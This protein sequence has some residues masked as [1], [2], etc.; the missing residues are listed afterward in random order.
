[1]GLLAK[2]ASSQ[3]SVCSTAARAFTSGAAPSK[4]E[5]LHALGN[6]DD[7]DADSAVV[8]YLSALYKGAKVEPSSGDDSLEFTSKIE[9]KYMAAETVEF[10][11]QTI[12]LPLS[13]NEEGAA[14]VKRYVA[15]LLALGK[16]AGF[17]DPMIETEK[18]LAEAAHVSDSV[19]ELLTRARTVM[20]PELH[21]SLTEAVNAVEAETGGAAVPLDGASPAYKKFADKAKAI[22][23][24]N[25]L[26]WKLLVDVKKSAA[27]EGTKDKLGKE[28]S[29]WLQSARVA[30]AVAE[31]AALRSEASSLLDKQLGKSAEQVRKE[32]SAALAQAMRRAESAKG[33][34]W[35]QAFLED[36]E[37]TKWFD[38]CVAENPAVG[39]KVAK[40]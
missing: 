2:T 14:S 12:A 16:K 9:K 7:P 19:K 21:A 39:P 23:T 3:A 26:P 1:M 24:A 31:L 11:I 22:A 4:K 35:A 40:A 13:H 33:A 32:Q 36:V 38:A 15:Q 34:A 6:R 25:K 5:I 10:G 28:Y 37:R 8:A 18:K 27:D 17:E 20:S 30:D 29:S